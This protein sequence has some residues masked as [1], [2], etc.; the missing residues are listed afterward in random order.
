MKMKCAI[1][2]VITAAVAVISGCGKNE[3]TEDT[4]APGELPSQTETSP[5]SENTS[6]SPTEE[7]TLSSES[8]TE[9]EQTTTGS[10][11]TEE[12]TTSATTTVTTTVLTTTTEQVSNKDDVIEIEDDEAEISQDDISISENENDETYLF[13]E[14]ADGIAVYKYLGSAQEVTIP[15]KIGN[16]TVVAVMGDN[17]NGK[18]FFDNPNKVTKINFPDT[19][20]TIGGI[21]DCENLTSIT[22]PAS[23]ESVTPQ[24][25]FG[26]INLKKITVES[27]N[28]KFEVNSL[29]STA[30]DESASEEYVVIGGTLY[31][32]NGDIAQLKTAVVPSG[33]TYIA[34]GVFTMATALEKVTIPESVT[35]IGDTNFSGLFG[36]TEFVC[37]KDSYAEDY[38]KSLGFSVTSK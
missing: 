3:N 38:I 36:E 26:C 30:W 31:R 9:E 21:W 14:M 11:G 4:K 2:A 13:F 28:T 27:K 8:T 25:F 20:K 33:V 5:V 17:A 37:A 12:T 7:V 32:Y 19:V 35:Q 23:V 6:E 24:A 10:E 1:F 22:I 18:S 16:K 34:D 15:S 29:L